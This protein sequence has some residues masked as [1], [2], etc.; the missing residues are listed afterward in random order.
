[1]TE[2]KIGD[3][4]SVMNHPEYGDAQVV[5]FLPTVGGVLLDSRLGGARVWLMQCLRKP[6]EPGSPV[7]EGDVMQKKAN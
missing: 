5:A 4:V 7:P 1:M 2:L 3:R 6:S